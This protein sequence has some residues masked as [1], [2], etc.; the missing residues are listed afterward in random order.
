MKCKCWKILAALFS[1]LLFGIHG[2]LMV[3]VTVG[4]KEDIAYLILL[5][6]IV[7]L[8]VELA[9]TL[10]RTKKGEWK[11]F[12][13]MVFLYLC[14]VIPSVFVMELELLEHRIELSNTTSAKCIDSEYKEYSTEAQAL[15]QLLIL[16]LI[17]GRWLMP[18]GQMSRDQLSQLLL[19]YLGLG[20]DILD[21]LDL[22]KDP[23]VNTNFPLAIVGLILFSWAIMQFTIVLTQNVSLPSQKTPGD[24]ES[25]TSPDKN[26]PAVT[27]CCTAQVWTL[28]ITVGMQD[29]PFL[30]YRIY[31]ASMEGV[32]NDSIVFFI[33]K[34]FLTVM[35]EIYRIAAFLCDERRNRK[36]PEQSHINM[37]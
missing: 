24:E 13:P 23:A 19:T 17:I 7:L 2:T 21:V 3:L 27:S 35:I 34:N 8:F 15:E 31:L 20:A 36:K 25:Q 9:V 12:S 14:T 10:W 11:W 30:V 18:K 1:R 22:I 29:G 37:E 5:I 33:C 16:V 4:I 32:D 6:G 26:R 28:V